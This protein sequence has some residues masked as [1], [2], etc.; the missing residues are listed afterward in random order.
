MAQFLNRNIFAFL[1]LILL[2][3][4]FVFLMLFATIA[5]LVL[6]FVMLLT[7]HYLRVWKTKPRLIIGSIALV[8]GI[9]LMMAV[10]T[11][12]ITSEAMSS[13]SKPTYSTNS[14]QNVTNITVNPY[15]STSATTYTITYV[16]KLSTNATFNVSTLSSL[17]QSSGHLFNVS[18]NYS[19]Y[20][21]KNYTFS[22]VL[23]NLTTYQNKYIIEINVT[24][25]KTY[26]LL[27]GPILISKSSFQN[28]VNDVNFNYYVEPL[29][30]YL[31][32]F[33]EVLY[34]LLVFGAILT[35]RGRLGIGRSRT[36]P[37]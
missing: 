34:V 30:V 36:P 26:T 31:F 2:V 13:L 28:M 1:M 37:Q 12:I 5:Y 10:L 24:Q 32:I 14:P 22:L 11:P 33:A 16:S 9:F 15:I 35:R 19:S 8:I 3:V 21:N 29:S 20:S 7:L 6:P 25:N 27:L 17:Y 23:T 4:V 18:V